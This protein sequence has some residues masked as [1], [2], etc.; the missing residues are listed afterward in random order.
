MKKLSFLLLL[1]FIYSSTFAQDIDALLS[2]LSKK[3][4]FTYQE[5]KT[6][7]FFIK[8]YTLFF[9]QPIDHKNPEK[10]NFKQR[11]FLSHV[12]FENPTLLITEGYSASYAN[13]PRYINELAGL[14]KTNQVCVEHRYFGT[15]V[16]E[17][18]E[19]DY[20]STYN[21]AADHH[22]IVTILKNLYHKKWISTGISKGGQTAMYHRYY[23]PDDVDITVGYVCPL[24]FSIEDKRVYQ[25]L[26][27]V[28]DSSSRK[29]IH[30]FQYE[31]F[32]NKSKYVKAFENLSNHRNL[33]YP[34]SMMEAYE[35]TVLEY[36][37]AFWQWGTTSLELIPTS[38]LSPELMVNH[39]DKVAG[40]D[41]ISNEGIKRLQ[42]FFY[43]ALSEIGFYGY[44][45]S[46]FKEVTSFT[47]NPSFEFTAPP[48]TTIV[49][50]P[51]PMQ[52]VDHFIRHEARN[53]MF[54]YGENDP[55]SATSVDLT[56]NNNL[57][58]VVKPGGSHLTRIN[59]LPENQYN[60][61]MQTLLDWLNH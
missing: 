28:G 59:N 12:S 27:E 8:K 32:K 61:V 4:N 15:S 2:D 22:Q 1:L 30:D 60:Q 23:Y 50:D 31:M 53:M 18:I 13:N 16:P 34:V 7:T 33:T 11:V 9:V 55:W 47:K 19:W 41:W 40:I 35:L 44:D 6:D 25:F 38:G 3:H 58:K 52:D 46:N 49:Y 36:A 14:L 10:G 48:G 21:A 57:L 45:I 5:I 17:V 29:K 43:Q 26:D 42:P 54:I 37:F 24:N 51:K 20:L 39:L 56:Y